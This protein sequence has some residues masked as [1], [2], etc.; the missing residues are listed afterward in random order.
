MGFVEVFMYSADLSPP[1]PFHFVPNLT[2]K[3]KEN[4]M[5]TLKCDYSKK[6]GLPGYSSHQFSISLETEITNVASRG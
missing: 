4:T 6:L 2:A 1:C 5:I 3:R